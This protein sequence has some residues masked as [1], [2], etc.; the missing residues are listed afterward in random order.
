MNKNLKVFSC[1]LDDKSY[2]IIRDTIENYNKK[3]IGFKISQRHFITKL[4]HYY[5]K[6][7]DN[8]EL[9]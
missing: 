3:M 9:F 8:I 4:L 2:E 7:K 1:K 6:N 5:D